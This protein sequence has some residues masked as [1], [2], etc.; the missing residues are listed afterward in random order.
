M[1]GSMTRRAAK[2]I[3]RYPSLYAFVVKTI[4]KVP[5][6]N[7]Y[8]IKSSDNFAHKFPVSV[9][10]VVIRDNRVA[11]LRNERNEW[12]LPGGKLEPSET[13]EACVVRE[14]YEELKLE[15]KASTLL[16]VWTYAPSKDTSVL[17]VT[18]GCVEEVP[19]EVQLSV[20]HQ[21]FAW[22]PVAN[23]GDL[24]MPDGYKHSV[25]AFVTTLRNAQ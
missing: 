13:P 5:F 4:S 2:I 18:F 22:F 10:G 6:L 19:R 17:I 21:Q 15:V 3:A 25:T 23:V 16:G 12:E 11:L 8:F 1:I 14:I 9:K 7:S 20:E 24:N